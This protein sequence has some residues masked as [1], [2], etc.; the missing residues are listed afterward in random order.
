[1]ITGPDVGKKRLIDDECG[2]RGL[3]ILIMKLIKIGEE[4]DVDF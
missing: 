3:R 1:M 4:G 2:N